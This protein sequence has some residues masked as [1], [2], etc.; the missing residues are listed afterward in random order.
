MSQ[1]QKENQSLFTNTVWTNVAKVVNFFEDGRLK[2]QKLN[3][4][5]PICAPE[6]KQHH[7]QPLYQL[8]PKMQSNLLNAVINESY[9]LFKEM[10]EKAD[11]YC[12][13]NKN[14]FVKC[15]NSM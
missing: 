10:K 14:A 4:K 8:P 6:I 13:M 12:Q 2:N 9:I 7:L 15:T 3:K 1:T 11:E 5:H